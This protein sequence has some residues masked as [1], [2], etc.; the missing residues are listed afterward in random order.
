[1]ETGTAI[2]SNPNGASSDGSAST[3][4]TVRVPAERADWSASTR[5]AKAL[6]VT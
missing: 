5:L 1:V 3:G 2:T 6:D 4:K